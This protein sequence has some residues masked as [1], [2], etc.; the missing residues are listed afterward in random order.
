MIYIRT[1]W[2]FTNLVIATILT[3]IVIVLTALLFKNQTLIT[4]LL[5]F[6]GSWVIK[7]AGINVKLH[8]LENLN[9]DSQYV[10][11][12]NHESSLDIFLTF[13]KIP[14]PFR[15]V[16]K[17]ELRKMPLVGIVMEQGLFPLINR[18]D[19][20]SAIE[21]L[22]GTFEK[23]K[24]NQLSVFVFPEGTRS[25]NGRLIPFKKGSFVLAIDNKLPILP[26]VMC[27]A[28]KINPP[29]TLWIKDSEI[30]MYFLPPVPVSEVENADRTELRDRVFRIMDNFQREQCC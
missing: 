14:L 1:L 19:R 30:D 9:P 12:G 16:A 5:R 2:V 27:G 11:L 23:M 13:A 18:K 25:G 24:E 7:A 22:N 28:G 10:I 4:R 17:A 3:G 26:V 20:S 6:W 8:G 29:G 15:I 21:S